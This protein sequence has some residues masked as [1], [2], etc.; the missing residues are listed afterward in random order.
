MD[1][2]INRD[3][4]NRIHLKIFGRIDALNFELFEQRMKTLRRMGYSDIVLDFKHVSFV[5]ISAM[6]LIIRFCKEINLEKTGL[7]ILDADPRIQENM[8]QLGSRH[9][10]WISS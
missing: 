6:I 3:S 7:V 8:N 9:L 2:H 4:E 5:N 10:K 1:I